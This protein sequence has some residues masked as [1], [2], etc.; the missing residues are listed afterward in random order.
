[1]TIPPEVVLT[2]ASSTVLVKASRRV[3]RDL[4][5]M[6]EAAEMAHEDQLSAATRLQG[7]EL[8]EGNL[9]NT[10]KRSLAQR[11]RILL[12]LTRKDSG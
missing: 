3:N 2:L 4:A 11:N 1:M 12:V 7:N 10:S 5:G 8:N 6:L 9:I